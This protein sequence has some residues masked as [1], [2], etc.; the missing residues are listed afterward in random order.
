MAYVDL[1]RGNS[2]P[3]G[4]DGQIQV[5][6]GAFRWEPFEEPPEQGRVVST[7]GAVWIPRPN[8]ECPAEVLPDYASHRHAEPGVLSEAPH[9][10]Y[11]A[12]VV[13]EQDEQ[14][15]QVSAKELAIPVHLEDIIR[16]VHH[17]VP[18]RGHETRPV[19]LIGR[20]GQHHQIGA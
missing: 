13:E 4:E 3:S 18:V 5:W 10:G 1:Y 2:S 7:Q 14:P 9:T 12:S 11:R 8:R 17:G 16:L 20:I 15:S 19:T 6:C